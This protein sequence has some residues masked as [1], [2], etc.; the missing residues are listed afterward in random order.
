MFQLESVGMQT[1]V[2]KQV[3]ELFNVGCKAVIVSP[4]KKVL[5]L[6]RLIRSNRPS[7]WEFPGGRIDKGESEIEALARELAEELGHRP[8]FEIEQVVHAAKFIDAKDRIEL[9]GVGIFYVFYKLKTQLKQI[10]LDPNEHTEHQW[11]S[12]EQLND[13][14]WSAEFELEPIFMKAALAALVD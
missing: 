7:Y 11:V 9:P 14:A 13:S 1:E 8:Q 10:K 2:K 5:L 4:D 6:K 3:Q 12:L